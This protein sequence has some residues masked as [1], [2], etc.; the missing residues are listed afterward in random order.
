MNSENVPLEDN[1]C[2]N[3]EAADAAATPSAPT[4]VSGASGDGARPRP[5]ARPAERPSA[6]ASS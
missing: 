3:Q 2:L 5:R 1:V 6:E 4:Q